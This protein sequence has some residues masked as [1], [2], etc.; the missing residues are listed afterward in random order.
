[1]SYTLVVRSVAEDELTEAVDWYEQRWPGKGADLIDAVDTIFRRITANPR[2]G[3]KVADPLQRML[4]PNFPYV[5]I[6]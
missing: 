1:M 3:R 4:V 6:Y 2:I 5:V